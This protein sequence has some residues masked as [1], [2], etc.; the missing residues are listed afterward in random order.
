MDDRERELLAVGSEAGRTSP[1]FERVPS[2]EMHTEL[3]RSFTDVASSPKLLR[4]D[5]LQQQTHPMRVFDC[6]PVRL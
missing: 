5:E 2:G 6:Q 1:S 4:A 3:P